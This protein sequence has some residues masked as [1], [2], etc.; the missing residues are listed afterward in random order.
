MMQ[1][2]AAWFPVL[3]LAAVAAVTVWLD[4]QVQPPEPA[5]NSKARHDPDYIV[6]NFT[7]TRIGPDGVVGYRLNARRMLHYPDDD[8]TFLDAPKLVNFR[9]SNV[10]VTAT[11]KTAT[12]SS[13]GEDAYLNEDV[14]LVRSAYGTH[15][16]L[17]VQTTWLH[18]IPDS[19]IA[20]TDKPVRIQDATTL[21]TSNGLEFNNDTHIMKFLS[22]VRGTYEKPK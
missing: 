1:R 14:R 18:V 4:R 11:S 3:L 19:G 6:D 9:D 10:T 7:V 16:A 15:S 12:L 8:T 21:I 2:L 22:N 5:G 20:K 13:N 17:T